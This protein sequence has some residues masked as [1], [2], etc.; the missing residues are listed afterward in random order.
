MY[1]NEQRELVT[2]FVINQLIIF[3][4][5][6]MHRLL[7]YTITRLASGSELCTVQLRC[8]V[9][10]A[11]ELLASHS[12][13][14]RESLTSH[15]RVARVSLA[16]RSRVTRKLLALSLIVQPSVYYT[17]IAISHLL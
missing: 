9:N 11:R 2:M 8:K 4:Y 1:S 17:C 12:Q 13:V 7:H 5:C 15:A 14:M 3:I 10:G 6:T 16:S